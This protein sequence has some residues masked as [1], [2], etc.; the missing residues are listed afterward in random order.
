[1]ENSSLVDLS[2]QKSDLS[3]TYIVSPDFNSDKV[4]FAGM[5]ESEF[6]AEKNV[7]RDMSIYVSK[8]RKKDRL[9]LQLL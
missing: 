3:T 5:H 9:F 8:W 2:D 7:T 4:V 6:K 1:M